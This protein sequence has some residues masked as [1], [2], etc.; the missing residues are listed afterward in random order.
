MLPHTPGQNKVQCLEMLNY[1]IYS[2]YFKVFFYFMCFT[3]CELLILLSCR[4][5]LYILNI[6]F[7]RYTAS[8][9]FLPIHGLP[10]HSVSWELFANDRMQLMINQVAECF[11][12]SLKNVSYTFYHE[13]SKVKILQISVMKVTGRS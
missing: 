12:N 7:V 11:E 8:D 1:F 6:C 3:H 5:A 10:I 13:A 2:I 4:S 9:S